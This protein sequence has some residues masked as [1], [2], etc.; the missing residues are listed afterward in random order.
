MSG[1][2]GSEAGEW[3]FAQPLPWDASV[4]EKLAAASSG[5]ALEEAAGSQAVLS[6]A[7]GGSAGTA[8]HPSQEPP[9][10]FEILVMYRSFS[11]L[12]ALQAPGY[13]A[14]ER[15]S[16][17][18]EDKQRFECF[19]LTTRARLHHALL[20]TGPCA[21]HATSLKHCHDVCG[22]K[23]AACCSMTGVRSC[24]GCRVYK[25]TGGR[26]SA[27]VRVLNLRTPGPQCCWCIFLV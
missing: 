12:S 2:Q 14:H 19:R 25:N 27:G 10:H 9:Y 23:I 21:E 18:G 7:V 5:E 6:N 8:S 3:G 16:G 17:S 11:L 22:S 1:E 4:P 24:K 20:M 15:C 13:W 26:A